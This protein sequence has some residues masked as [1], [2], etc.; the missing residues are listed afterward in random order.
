[1]DILTLLAFYHRSNVLNLCTVR[2][3]DRSCRS[4]L[5]LFDILIKSSNERCKQEV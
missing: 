2:T 3:L 5:N 4:V 1:M